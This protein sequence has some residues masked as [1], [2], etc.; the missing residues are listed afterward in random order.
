MKSEKPSIPSAAVY[1]KM[2]DDFVERGIYDQED[3]PDWEGDAL[4]SYLVSQMR[5]PWLRSR[6]LS[7]KIQA[8]VFYNITLDFVFQHLNMCSYNMLRSQ[9]VEFKIK[10]VMAWDYERKKDGWSSLMKEVEERNPGFSK[11]YQQ[12]FQQPEALKDDVLW[13]HFLN[14]WKSVEFEKVNSTCQDATRGRTN[15][16]AN[17]TRT[18]M[19]EVEEYVS[20]NRIPESEFLQAW[21]AMSGIWNSTIYERLR[22]LIQIQNKYPVLVKIA[23]KMGRVAD[24][25]SHQQLTVSS[26]STF[27]MSHS[28][29]SDVFGVTVGDDLN[30]MLPMEMAQSADDELSDLFLYKY[31]SKRLQTFSHK[32]EVFKPIHHLKMQSAKR[33]G[34]M[35]VCLDTS[36]S[37]VGDPEKVGNSLLLR[38]LEIADRQKRD[39]FLLSF[40]VSVNPIDVKKDRARLFDFFKKSAS[41][42]TNAKEM[43]MKMFDLLGNSAEYMSSD[44]LWIT[45]FKI[46]LV[47][48]Q[49]LEQMQECRRNGTRFYGLQI[50]LNDNQNW[51]TYFDEKY[52]LKI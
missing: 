41:G 10:S 38:L 34:P 24:E 23:N 46:P 17:Q 22:K 40:A 12:K 6:V 2:L 14:E 32:S 50:G 52:E 51:D 39:L 49:L 20:K 35:I 7:N 13:Q 28:S 4:Y 36:G 31:V 5:D 33:K 44:V 43:M 29:K 8:S 21:S 30:S 11:F 48:E 45:D 1:V 27:Q 42:D 19:K 15:A 18:S 37:M 26:G 25:E 9:A 47:T 16:V 3:N